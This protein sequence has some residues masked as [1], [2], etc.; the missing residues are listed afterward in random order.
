MALFERS[1]LMTMSEGRGAR[2]TATYCGWP[3]PVRC[4]RKFGERDSS[5]LRPSKSGNPI[6]RFLKVAFILTLALC[7]HSNAQTG[8]TRGEL[9]NDLER[10]E[11]ALKAND[12]TAAAE[13]FR[14][15]LKIDPANVEANADL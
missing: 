4:A 1:C 3:R 15:A 5:M 9:T 8:S 10:G 14:A 7:R 13:Q 6:S 12:Q 2:M 11:Q